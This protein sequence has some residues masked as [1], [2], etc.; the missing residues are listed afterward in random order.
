MWIW[1]LK[2]SYNI[3]LMSFP[4][5]G[6]CLHSESHLTLCDPMGCSPPGS[7]ELDRGPWNFPGKNTG[8]S[9][10]FLLQRTFLTQGLNPHLLSPVSPA[11]VG[12]FLTSESLAFSI[13]TKHLSYNVTITFVIWGATAKPAWISFSFLKFQ[14]E[15]SSDLD[16]SKL[17]TH[18]FF[19][20]L[21]KSRTY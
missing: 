20:F 14:R 17:C 18:F 11:L 13:L 8:S 10:H 1:S 21:S 16:F 12:R 7:E 6:A 3:N 19:C 5:C 4:S 9:C 15:I 2:I